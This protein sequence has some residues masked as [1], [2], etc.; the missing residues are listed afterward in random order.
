[1]KRRKPTFIDLFAGAGGAST[2]LINAGFECI[3]AIEIDDWAAD[4]YELNHPATEVIRGDIQH[5]SD[6]MLKKYKGV[7]LIVGGPPCQGFSIAASNRRKKDDPRNQLYLHYVRAVEIV[8]PRFIIVENVKEIAKFKIA[9]GSLLLDDF[10]KRLEIL[11]YHLSYRLLNAKNFGAP[12]DRIRFFLVGN[13]KE[14]ISLEAIE[15]HAENNA[16]FG[17]Q[18]VITLEEAISDLPIPKT[19]VDEYLYVSPPMNDY[20]RKMRQDFD[21]VYNHEPMRHTERIIERFKHIPIDGCM[22]NAPINHRNRTRGNVEVLSEKIYYQNHRRLNPKEPCKTITASFYSSFIHPY[23]H[24]NLTVRE[25]ARIQGFPDRFKFLGKR[26]T[27][28]NKLLA[29][30]GIH[31][32]IHLD[33]FNQVGNAVSPIVAETLGRLILRHL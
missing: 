1:M 18:P 10:V 27:L 3:A 23:Q 22:L 21:K 8:K 12:Q 32:D 14:K 30:K 31:E 6:A 24:R 28:S 13:L 19:G 25:A 29:K 11:G 15:T 2:G 4:T 5:V 9:D 16:L 7:D 33:Q 20:Q 17:L 26:T